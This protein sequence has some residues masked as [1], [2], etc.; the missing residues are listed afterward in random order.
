MVEK[1]TVTKKEVKVS[2]LTFHEKVMDIQQRLEVL[3][4]INNDFGGF[5]YRNLDSIEEKL[6]PLLKEHGLIATFTDDIVGV[7][8]RVYVQSTFAV[9]DGVKEISNSAFAREA[10]KPKAKMDDAQLTGSCSSYA[11]KY[12]VDGMFLL[13]G[14]KDPDSRDNNEKAVPA[15]AL[16][17]AKP[18]L[19]AIPEEVISIEQLSQLNFAPK[20]AGLDKEQSKT[21]WGKVESKMGLTRGKPNEDFTVWDGL[22]IAPSDVDTILLRLREYSVRIKNG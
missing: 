9:T 2:E 20:S 16:T 6:R 17:P 21:F 4:D 18:G 22:N 3:K 11:R 19:K 15:P 1:K 7:G 8:D 13:G 10:E 14:N 5:T 12:A